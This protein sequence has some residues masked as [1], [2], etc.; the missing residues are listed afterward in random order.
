M[1]KRKLL[2]ALF[3]SMNLV[4]SSTIPVHATENVEKYVS[5]VEN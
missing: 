3:I 1:S 5:F 4:V 2:V